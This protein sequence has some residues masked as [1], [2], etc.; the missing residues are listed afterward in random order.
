MVKI[1]D[2]VKLILAFIIESE[3]LPILQHCVKV[4]NSV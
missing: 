2:F 1:F 3:Y 4:K